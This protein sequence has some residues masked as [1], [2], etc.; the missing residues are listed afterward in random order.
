MD[1]LSLH[2]TGHWSI[3]F[4][5]NSFIS[6]Y[7]L[8]DQC[9]IVRLCIFLSVDYNPNHRFSKIC[10]DST[11]GDTLLPQIKLWGLDIKVWFSYLIGCQ[12]FTVNTVHKAISAHSVNNCWKNMF[13]AA[14]YVIIRCCASLDFAC[15]IHIPHNCAAV[16][17]ICN[18]ICMNNQ[19]PTDTASVYQIY[20]DISRYWCQCPWKPD[21]CA[22]F[23]SWRLLSC[24]VFCFF[25]PI[26]LLPPP[27][28]HF[29]QIS[30]LSKHVPPK[31]LFQRQLF[32]NPHQ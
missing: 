3:N 28:Y 31:S 27:P 19:F 14:P 25:L 32:L 8:C 1:K 9:Q 24:F 22:S 10:T 2:D 5:P 15:G 11:P 21:H 18:Q 30:S 16:N 7:F 6:Q 20:Q 13:W 29:H 12:K 23:C 17:G 26:C 4:S